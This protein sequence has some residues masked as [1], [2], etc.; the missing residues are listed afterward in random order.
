MIRW[1][2]ENKLC[3]SFT[4][5]KYMLFKQCGN[6]LCD[7][8]CFKIKTKNFIEIESVDSTKY[9]GIIFD[10]KLTWGKHIQYISNKLGQA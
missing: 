6:K 9:I 10:K 2:D 7:K 4:K 8:F 3:T 5:T 1:M